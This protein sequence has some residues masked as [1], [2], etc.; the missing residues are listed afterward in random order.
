[1]GGRLCRKT[2]DGLY[3]SPNGGRAWKRSEGVHGVVLGIAA[4]LDYHSSGVVLAGTEDTGLWRSTDG[5]HC[6]TPVPGAPQQVNA[7]VAKPDGWLLSDGGEGIW[8]SADGLRWERVAG[9]EPS[10]VMLPTDKGVLAAAQD[11]VT[12]VA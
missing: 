7:L 10:L 9:S 12:L 6:F 1:M 8:R 4:A 5:G 11:G 3:R 2:E